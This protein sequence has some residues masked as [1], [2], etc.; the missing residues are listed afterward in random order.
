MACSRFVCSCL[1]LP[2]ICFVVD[3]TI[4]VRQLVANVK[5]GSELLDEVSSREP[6]RKSEGGNEGRERATH[7]MGQA[8]TIM[9]E[10]FPD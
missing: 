3:N 9:H 8:I 5:K 4:D 1:E 7:L 6:R 2:I 10:G